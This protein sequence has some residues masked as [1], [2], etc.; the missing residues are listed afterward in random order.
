MENALIPYDKQTEAQRA[1]YKK[2]VLRWLCRTFGFKNY[3]HSFM[4]SFIHWSIWDGELRITFDLRQP[5]QIKLLS[6]IPKRF[7]GRPQNETLKI[8]NENNFYINISQVIPVAYPDIVGS[9]LL[10]KLPRKDNEGDTYYRYN[11]E[12]FLSDSTSILYSNQKSVMDMAKRNYIYDST[13]QQRE[14]MRFLLTFQ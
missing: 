7:K 10:E 4:D 2:L 5:E 14:F 11:W 6:K 9:K 8:I 1:V 3:P 12:V 13:I